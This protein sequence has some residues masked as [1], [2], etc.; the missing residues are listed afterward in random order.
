MSEKNYKQSEIGIEDTF[1]TITVTDALEELLA[2]SDNE[3]NEYADLVD[4]TVFIQ[5]ANGIAHL[6]CNEY[7]DKHGEFGWELIIKYLEDQTEIN[8][9]P[10]KK[11]IV[12][13]TPH[14]IYIPEDA[15]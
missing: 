6:I 9:N 5:G 10:S 3:I 1:T 13:E 14:N 11:M 8:V 15:L 12:L 7:E 2:D 4:K